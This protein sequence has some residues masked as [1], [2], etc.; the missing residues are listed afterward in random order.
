MV[1]NFLYYNFRVIDAAAKLRESDTI[2]L[3]VLHLNDIH[4]RIEQTDKYTGF[5]DKNEAGINRN[6]SLHRCCIIY[7]VDTSLKMSYQITFTFY[8]KR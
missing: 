6:L 8:S 5:C 4:A 3:T 1:V 2:D 7:T